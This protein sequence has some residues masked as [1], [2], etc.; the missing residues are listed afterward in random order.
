[1][2]SIRL[3]KEQEWRRKVDLW[4][5]YGESPNP[6]YGKPGYTVKRPGK[7]RNEYAIGASG[8]VVFGGIG[9]VAFSRYHGKTLTGADLPKKK[10][11][12]RR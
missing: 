7:L 11:R 10:K 3:N 4:A 8:G 9:G 1:M 6:A 2:Q 5:A 12:G